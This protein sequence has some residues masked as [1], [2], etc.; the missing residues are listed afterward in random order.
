M[1]PDRAR[2][3]LLDA[4]LA[5]GVAMVA[6][7]AVRFGQRPAPLGDGGWPHGPQGRP[8]FVVTSIPWAIYP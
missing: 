5:L 6:F 2:R 8:E 7:A 4:P 1:R 3:L